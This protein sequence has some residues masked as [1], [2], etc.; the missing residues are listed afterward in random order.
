MKTTKNEILKDKSTRTEKINA[1]MTK[2]S[3]LKNKNHMMTIRLSESIVKY[4][5]NEE[6]R[7]SIEKELGVAYKDYTGLKL[8]NVDFKN[9]LEFYTKEFDK[10]RL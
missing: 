8:L 4:D 3:K 5:E 7:L 9:Q 2:E 10:I 1:M 6:V